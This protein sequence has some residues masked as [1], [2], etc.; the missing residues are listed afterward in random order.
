MTEKEFQNLTSQGIVLL[1]G[2]MGT[3]LMLKGMPK[4]VCT[5]KWVYEHPD[6]QR[7]IQGA[8]VEAGSKIIYAPTFQ[9]N[10]ISFS[11]FGMEGELEKINRTMVER[12]K[13]IAGDCALVAGDISSTG[14]YEEPY[15]NLLEVYK[16]QIS[17]LADSK[18]DILVIET[19]IKV[20]ETMAAIDAAK[21]VCDLPIMCTMTVEADGS[22][23]MGGNIYEAAATY[24]AMG[25][26]AVGINCSLGPDQLEAIVKGIR[27][28]VSIPVVIKPNAGVPYINDR[29]EAIYNM[30]P[31][32]FAEHML[33]LI[34][35][36]A[37]LVGGCCGTNA[38]YIRALRERL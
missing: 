25:A 35:A 3:N 32:E 17:Y 9:A 21:N 36:G 4:G 22:L 11:K 28:I 13:Q 18:A 38:A 5:E 23:L 19:M 29:G 10:R 33:K 6:V 20:E 30:G 7:E 26:A 27:D 34:K 12:T 16:E 2:A 37:N 24:E 1:D 8:Y 15:E 31:I 14:N